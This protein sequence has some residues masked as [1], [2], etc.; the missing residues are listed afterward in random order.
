MA[1]MNTFIQ[2]A[3][4]LPAKLSLVA[5][6]DHGIGKSQ[7]VRQIAKKLGLEVLDLRL[8]LMSDGDF[9]GLPEFVDVPF[10]DAKKEAD[11]Q[12][13]LIQALKGIEGRAASEAI[14]RAIASQYGRVNVTRFAP[15]AWLIKVQ[16]EPHVLFLDEANRAM[17]EV[18]QASFQLVLERNLNGH[19]VHPDTRII[20][21]VNMGSKYRVAAFDPALKDRFAIVKLEPSID[22]WLTWA[23]E[24]GKIHS[25]IRAFIATN[26]EHL[27][28]V[29]DLDPNEIYPSRR[30]WEHASLALSNI[31]AFTGK[32][33]EGK[34]SRVAAIVQAI[35]GPNAMH[36]FV[37]YLE[38]S[39]KSVTVLDI[40]N[41]WNNIKDRIHPEEVDALNAINSRIVKHLK[42]HAFENDQQAKNLAAY[43]KNLPGEILI[44]LFCD[45]M[46]E[47]QHKNT[48]HLTN[49]IGPMVQEV[50]DSSGMTTPKDESKTEEG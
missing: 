40:L 45:V 8:A 37:T 24:S 4:D 22:D 50:V 41:D 15:P 7:V 42:D 44:A 5:E 10:A 32:M 12:A 14:T 36:A 34:F 18:M 6:G 31:D 25:I 20:A 21:A 35:C 3:L 39:L 48:Y 33:S 28:H 38:S 49:F 26:P 30:S 11:Y 27:E 9:I 29:G 47:A 16:R 46:A 19:Y 23:K 2:L 13:E 1:T 17:P 43:M